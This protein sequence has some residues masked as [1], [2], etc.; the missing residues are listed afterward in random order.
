M[1]PSSTPAG[2]VSDA[3]P[4]R[5]PSTEP[6]R[7][8]RFA[9]AVSD[10][11]DEGSA[12]ERRPGPLATPG[13]RHGGWPTAHPPSNRSC[14]TARGVRPGEHVECARRP[15][16]HALVP[17]A[18]S[19]RARRPADRRPPEDPRTVNTAG[20]LPRA[21]PVA[22]PDNSTA[23]PSRPAAPSARASRAC[24]RQQRPRHRPDRPGDTRGRRQPAPAGRARGGPRRVVAPGPHR[25]G[26][27][28]VKQTLWSGRRLPDRPR[29]GA[30]VW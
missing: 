6:R 14:L 25:T 11:A 10:R 9:T 21:G 2:V 1:A 3:P 13:R 16:M 23:D 30:V 15:D 27:F 7:P 28:H 24:R 5:G 26:A 22:I 17:G 12:H 29:A 4:Y 19:P 18:V 8:H 20:R